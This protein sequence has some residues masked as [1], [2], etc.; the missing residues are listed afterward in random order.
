MSFQS[1][2]NPPYLVNFTYNSKPQNGKTTKPKL[3]DAEQ[4]E[5]YMAN[6][7]NPLKPEIEA[8]R[9]IIKNTDKKIGERIKWNAPSYYYIEDILTFGPARPGKVML[10]FH[11]PHVVNIASAL[12]EGDYK[13]RRLAHFKDMKEVKANKKHLTA[14]VNEIITAID[15]KQIKN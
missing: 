7:D 13:D 10:V 3:S 4:V 12:L 2:A 11:H 15:T 9:E 5:Q 6:L 14:I 8:L 1:F